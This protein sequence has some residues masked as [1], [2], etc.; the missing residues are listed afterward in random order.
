[1]R[2]RGLLQGVELVSD[3]E[4]KAPSNELVG[5]VT[6]RCLELGL[7]VNIVQVPGAGGTLR[8]APALTSTEQEIDLGVEILDQALSDAR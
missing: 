3:R 4:T 1:M 5:K 7:H 6:T 2:G 8:L